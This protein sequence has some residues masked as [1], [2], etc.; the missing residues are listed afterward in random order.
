MTKRILF[1]AILGICICSVFWQAKT[2]A[3]QN[4]DFVRDIQPIFKANCERCHGAK[5]SQADLRL[6]EK[7]FALKVI[8][9]GNSKA[10]RLM[11]RILGEGG[12]PRMPMGGEPL[13]PEEIELIRKWVDQLKDEGGGMNDESRN[14][15][16]EIKRHWAFIPPVRPQVPEVKNKSWVRNPIDN[17]VL[18]KLEQIG[19]TPSPEA[20][21]T[22]LIRRLSLDL[23]GLLAISK[24]LK[25]SLQMLLLTRMKN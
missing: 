5:I 10:S 23:T 13:K 18:A 24:K 19:L 8:T 1:L 3:V 11:Q 14:L 2:N 15:K 4:I 22:Q 12:E 6:D 16:S 9:P 17:F 20:S 7:S 25:N 21:K